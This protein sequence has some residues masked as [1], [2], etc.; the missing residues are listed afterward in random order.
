MIDYNNDG[1]GKLNDEQEKQWLTATTYASIK[2]PVYTD[3]LSL[4]IPYVN[5]RIN[6]YAVVDEKWR[7][8]VNPSFFNLSKEEQGFICCHEASHVLSLH[9]Q[10]AKAAHQ[11]DLKT[12]MLSQDIEI[13]QQFSG[14]Y[15]LTMPDSY[16]MPDDYNLKPFQTMETYYPIIIQQNGNGEGS[17]ESSHSMST[18]SMNADNAGNGS[19]NNNS[20]NQSSDGNN[21]RNH[22]NGNHNGK[23]GS[24]KPTGCAGD[25][26]D[27]ISKDADNAGINGAGTADIVNTME[28]TK[29]RA[30]LMVKKYGRGSGNGKL[31]GW[32]IDGMTPPAVDWRELMRA[33]VSHV[34][35]CKSFQAIDR[36]F[37][38]IN[39]RA[40]GFIPDIIMPGYVSFN[41]NVMFAL[42]TSGSM[43]KKEIM[44]ALTE[45]QSI[46][47]NG[48]NGSCKMRAF[49]VDTEIKEEQVVSDV[50]DL[51]VTGRG[52]TDMMPAFRYI[53]DM[54]A[55]DKPDLFVL[56]TDGYVPWDACRDYMP[57]WECSVVILITD[58][59]G[60]KQVPAWLNDEATVLSIDDDK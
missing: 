31:A 33:I 30:E 42:D 48:L 28:L 44:K 35:T 55:S 18:S 29:D 59:S 23:H 38:K 41:P 27:K 12:S 22:N 53:R 3:A 45:C 21:S 9:F 57:D 54:R 17:D 2:A 14:V 60:L 7:I 15:G 52:G 50:N 39:K 1:I 46:I 5:S 8:A 58:R 11:S 24:D 19:H 47:D 51:N 36:S 32:L 4:L 37:S 40:A 25:N 20:K 49:C 34:K 16:P 10:R 13:D 6:G 43:D 56:A 26:P